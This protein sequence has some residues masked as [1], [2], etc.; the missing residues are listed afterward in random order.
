MSDLLP[1]PGSPLPGLIDLA[2]ARVGGR[3]PAANDEFFAP[4][5]NLQGDPSVTLGRGGASGALHAGALGGHS[6]GR[7]RC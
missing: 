5:E 7:C 6:N 2:A 1:A 3:A 4:K